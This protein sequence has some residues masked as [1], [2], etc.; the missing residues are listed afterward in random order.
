VDR[1]LDQVYFYA[2]GA[3]F[4]SGTHAATSSFA[5]TTGNTN[6]MGIVTDGASLWVVNSATTDRVYKYTTAG[7][8]LGNWAIDPANGNPTGLTIDPTDVNHI[9]IVDSTTDSVY[10]YDNAA[11]V[12]SGSLAASAVWAL[13][14][15]NTSPQD[16]ADPP[17][18]LRPAAPAARRAVVAP[19][20]GAD[21]SGLIDLTVTRRG[22][23]WGPTSPATNDDDEPSLVG[24]P[25]DEI[26][27]V[28]GFVELARHP[29]GASAANELARGLWLDLAPEEATF[30]GSRFHRSR[31]V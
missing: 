15:G 16:I 18:P 11:G 13:A 19:P 26:G 27:P 24:V 22:Q 28:G 12:T 2:G 21:W 8:S 20:G 31:P 29:D 30:F 7:V 23:P 1:T 5:L 9:W 6:P 3:A 14:S 25:G 4:L 10:R 17:P